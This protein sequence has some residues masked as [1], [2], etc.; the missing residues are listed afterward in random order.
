MLLVA[1]SGV[2]ALVA[3][4]RLEDKEPYK[5]ARQNRKAQPHVVRHDD[6]HQEI[7]KGKTR[8]VR[9][10]A[11]QLLPNA[12]ARWRRVGQCPPRAQEPTVKSRARK[13]EELERNRHKKNGDPGAGV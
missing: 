10:P 4:A 5:G 13:R 2:V 6:K 8:R 3:G 12:K 7:R 9:Q 1:A 11:Q